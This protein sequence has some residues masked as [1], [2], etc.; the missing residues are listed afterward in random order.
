VNI[1]ARKKSGFFGHTGYI[2]KDANYWEIENFLEIDTKLF[3][4][5]LNVSESS[6]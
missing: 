2:K 3:I 1:H 4:Y 6:L 5:R